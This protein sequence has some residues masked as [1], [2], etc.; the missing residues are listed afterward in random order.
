MDVIDAA[1]NCVRH[2]CVLYNIDE[3]HAVKH[4]MDVLHHTT[5]SYEYHV[6]RNPQL[7]QQRR[8]LFTAAIVHDMCDTKYVDQLVGLRAIH[9]YLHPVLSNEDFNVLALILTTMSYVTVKEKGFPNMNEWQLGYHIVREADLLA[10][11]DMDRFIIYGMY[12]KNMPYSE[13]LLNAETIFRNRTLRYIED[14]LFLTEYGLSTAHELH[15]KALM[16]VYP[17]VPNI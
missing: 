4:S 1:F 17:R 2:L 11:Y 13:A 5:Q 7:I 10:A 12:R 15:G 6:A 8:V 14:G 16:N 9:E 3:S